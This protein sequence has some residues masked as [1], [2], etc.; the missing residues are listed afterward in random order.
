M[1]VNQLSV[2]QILDTAIVEEDELK[3]TGVTG[4]PYLSSV[5]VLSVVSSTKTVNFIGEP[6]LLD[7][8]SQGD[9]LKIISGIS[10]GVYTVDVVLDNSIVVVEDI[11]DSTSTICDFYYPNGATRVGFDPSDTMYDSTDNTVY[12]ALLRVMSPSAVSSGVFHWARSGAT[13][14][15]YLYN[16]GAGPISSNQ[17]G[18]PLFFASSKLSD[19][20][21]GNDTDNITI[22]VKVYAHSSSSLTLVHSQLVVFSSGEYEKRFNN[23]NKNIT[24]GNM[25]AVRLEYNVGNKPNNLQVSAGVVRA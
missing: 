24:G 2:D 9:L 13:S 5:A 15:A 25:L 12:K 1:T 22:T 7:R 8:I 10:V 23:L 14:G 17:V 18:I 11:P 19:L 4:T 20:S 16:Y 3:S 6:L 21:V